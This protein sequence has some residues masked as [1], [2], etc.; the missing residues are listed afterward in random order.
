[1]TRDD[2]QRRYCAAD[3][4]KPAAHLLVQTAKRAAS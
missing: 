1:M 4:N 3:S 2:G